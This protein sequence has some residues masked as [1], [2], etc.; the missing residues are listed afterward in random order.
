LTLAFWSAPLFCIPGLQH[1]CTKP[2]FRVKAGRPVAWANR[3]Q[4]PGL[5]PSKI[6][7][8]PRRLFKATRSRSA[9]RSEFVVGS[10]HGQPRGQVVQFRAYLGKGRAAPG[11]NQSDEVGSSG[12]WV[13]R[14]IVVPNVG[15]LAAPGV[16]LV[17]GCLR[18]AVWLPGT[19]GRARLRCGHGGVLF[20]K[21][22]YPEYPLR[23]V[24]VGRDRQGTGRPRR[25]YSSSTAACGAVCSR[26]PTGPGPCHRPRNENS[27][28]RSSPGGQRTR[29]W[30][31]RASRAADRDHAT[32]HPGARLADS[33]SAPG[34]PPGGCWHVRCASREPAWLSAKRNRAEGP[35]TRT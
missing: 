11:S 8:S 28:I 18:S 9:E 30:S 26:R 23:G 12:A 27:E 33:R 4:A 29:G 2:L 19:V 7:R 20:S 6:M 24:V 21:G 10:T 16:A 32:A 5:A 15:F 14:G 17:P 22:V 3:L 35:V 34:P 13:H 31:P 1:S 25:W